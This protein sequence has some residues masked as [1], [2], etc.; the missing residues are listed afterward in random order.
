MLEELE[1]YAK[2]GT[3]ENYYLCKKTMKKEYIIDKKA[4]TFT[5]AYCKAMNMNMHGI[6]KTLVKIE[7][8]NK[9]HGENI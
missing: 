4:K 2:I 3:E 6:Y 9:R 7:E 8:R 1:W 5:K